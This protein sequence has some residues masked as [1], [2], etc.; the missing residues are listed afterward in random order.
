MIRRQLRCTDREVLQR[1]VVEDHVGAPLPAA[2]LAREGVD[3]PGTVKR[4][5]TADP[6]TLVAWE[7]QFGWHDWAAHHDAEVGDLTRFVTT[8]LVMLDVDFAPRE[9]CLPL[10]DSFGVPYEEWDSAELARRI[11]GIDTGRYW[12][13]A[14][15]DDDL[16]WRDAQATLGAVFT[17]DGGYVNDPRLAAQNLAAAAVEEG[18]EF[19][20]RREVTAF[21]MR[22]GRVAGVRLSGGEAVS[23]SIVVNAAGPWSGRLNEMAGVGKDFTVGLRPMRQEVHQ[24]D[25]PP[26]FSP[27]SRCTGTGSPAAGSPDCCP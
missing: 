2:G 27:T 21:E 23:C 14:R 5:S 7:A 8:G 16:F 6:W 4:Y 9:M 3:E 25:A 1:R 13:P 22:G 17:P 20:L 15:I 18:A 19:L 26:G 10:F 11:P 24:V 12:P